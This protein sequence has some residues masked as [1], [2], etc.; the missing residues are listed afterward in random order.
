MNG[1]TP[2]ISFVAGSRNDD[3][4][5]QLLRRMNIFVNGLVQQCERHRLRAELV[6]VEWNPPLDRPPL[7]EAIEWPEPSEFCELRVIQVPPE[8]HAGFEHSDKLPFFQMIAKNVGIRRARGRF[9]CATNIDVLFSNELF[10][11]LARGNLSDDRFYRVDRFDVSADVPYPAPVGDQLDHCRNNLL[12]VARRDDV[13]SATGGRRPRPLPQ[14]RYHLSEAVNKVRTSMSPRTREWV[15]S[16]LP[17]KLRKTILIKI[18][19]VHTNAC[20]DFTL[21]SRERWFELRAYPEI[22][23]YSLHIDSLFCY[24]AYYGGTP[25]VILQPPRC[26]YHLDHT[27]GWTP[28]EAKDLEERMRAAGIPQLTD[29]EMVEREAAMRSRGAAEIFNDEGWGLAVH[30]LV[31]LRPTPASSAT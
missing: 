21:M 27:G 23:A 9:V 14:W 12:R 24:A 2:Y 5:G 26:I 29:V 19:A 13:I 31:E 7:I 20:G 6:L 25:Q 22:A 18:P 3:H 17:W 11:F 4:G 28:E 8:L 1:S 10:A 16:I 30:D 15:A